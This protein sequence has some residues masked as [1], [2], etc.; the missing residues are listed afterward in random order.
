MLT[1]LV[2]GAIKRVGSAGH[3]SWRKNVATAT[4]AAYDESANR[5]LT[6]SHGDDSRAVRLTEDRQINVKPGVKAASK[7]KSFDVNRDK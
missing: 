7:A 2:A 3:V 5:W 1:Q 4:V 6:D